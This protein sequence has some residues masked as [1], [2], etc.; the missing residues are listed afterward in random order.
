MSVISDLTHLF[1]NPT[2]ATSTFSWDWY[3]HFSIY[4]CSHRG[5]DSASSFPSSPSSPSYYILYNSYLFYVQQLLTLSVSNPLPS[6]KHSLFLPSRNFSVQLVVNNNYPHIQPYFFPNHFHGTI[7][8]WTVYMFT[9]RQTASGVDVDRQIL[10]LGSDDDYQ[11]VLKEDSL[12]QNF[13]NHLFHSR[14]SKRKK[15]I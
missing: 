10:N 5:I 8:Y 3:I 4:S 1:H 2:T 9:R 15:S 6:L 11:T 13:R 14:Y 12:N 7:T